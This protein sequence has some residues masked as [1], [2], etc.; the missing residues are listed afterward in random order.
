MKIAKIMSAIAAVA[1]VSGAIMPAQAIVKC[2]S[3]S[4]PLNVPI[5][6]TCSGGFESVHLGDSSPKEVITRLVSG[7]GGDARTWGIGSD[8]VATKIPE[9][10][11]RDIVPDGDEER[12]EDCSGTEHPLA[13][14]LAHLYKP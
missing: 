2:D 7:A 11:A 13:T 14:I 8:G 1:A 12:S 10:F 3:D 9:C 5:S 6:L 4:G